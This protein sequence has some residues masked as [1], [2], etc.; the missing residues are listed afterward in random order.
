MKKEHE[1]QEEPDAEADGKAGAAQRIHKS[2]GFTHIEEIELL[3][4]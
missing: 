2:A 3:S 4:I 1:E